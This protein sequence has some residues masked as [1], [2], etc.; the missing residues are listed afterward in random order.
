MKMKGHSSTFR[1][2][3]IS[4]LMIFSVLSLS[5]F[6]Q[7]WIKMGETITGSESGDNLG[8]WMVMSTDG[9][10]IA[11]GAAG[12][13][14]ME[15]DMGAARVF[16]WTG[17]TWLQKGN[18]ITGLAED[19]ELGYSVGLSNDGNIL[20]V[21]ATEDTGDEQKNGYAK[22]FEWDGGNWVQLGETIHGENPYDRFGTSVC[23]SG[24]GHIL[25][26]GSRNGAAG[27]N[28]GNV[29][30]YEWSGSEWMHIGSTIQGTYEEEACG[31]ALD[32]N[33]AGNILAVGF[34]GDGVNT[35][36]IARI[37][38]YYEGD[39]Q[40]IGQDLSGDV[41]S[42]RFGWVLS[43]NLVGD[44]VGIGSRDY[45][46]GNTNEGQVKVFT[47][48]ENNWELIGSPVSGQDE[49]EY[50]GWSLDLSSD[51]MTFVAGVPKFVRTG[52]DE[53]HARVYYFD[54]VDWVMKGEQIDGENE[55]DRSGFTVAMNGDGNRVILGAPFADAEGWGEGKMMVYQFGN[56]DI[57][58][59]YFGDDF[60]V[61]PNPFKN[62]FHINLGKT[63]HHITLKVCAINGQLISRSRYHQTHI[64]EFNEELSE[65]I[66][67][68]EITSDKGQSA[69]IRVV[70]SL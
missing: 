55:G 38:E 42:A 36:G 28:A 43:L 70:K 45:D 21:G 69:V 19:D 51:G 6:A 47:R 29:K 52:F 48:N 32:L 23:L 58:E 24:D 26:V 3:K 53:G 68:M 60:S 13:D 63:Y 12:S 66:Y 9:N 44:V 27:Y 62:S 57:R 20:A 33:D 56:V 14:G 10:T 64:I 41:P 30:V 31:W 5:L 34:P 18:D 40:Q 67:L 46:G 17:S 1:F 49:Y 2:F 15:E 39:W 61:Y 25:A 37:Y 54:G 8:Y 16:I 11:A 7:E 50:F 4:S 59:N 22:V 35:N 65:G